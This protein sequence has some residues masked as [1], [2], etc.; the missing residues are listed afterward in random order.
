M[1]LRYCRWIAGMC[2]FA[3][4]A[5]SILFGLRIYIG[6]VKRGRIYFFVLVNKSVPLFSFLKNWK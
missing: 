1:F 3:A 5:E 6:S 2:V 4:I